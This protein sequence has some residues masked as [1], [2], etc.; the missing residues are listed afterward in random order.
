M[1]DLGSGA[2]AA[3]DPGRDLLASHGRPSLAVCARKA[4]AAVG[5]SE[6][7][8]RAER[9]LT[10]HES[11]IRCSEPREPDLIHNR[12]PHPQL[13]QPN[14][15]PMDTDASEGPQNTLK[16]RAATEHQAVKNCP[17]ELR[18]MLSPLR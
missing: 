15:Y 5:S 11:Y 1:D 18:M 8:R 12:R 3:S 2:G 9:S 13:F 14:E 17:T 16:G 10:S 6:A 7:N 4:A